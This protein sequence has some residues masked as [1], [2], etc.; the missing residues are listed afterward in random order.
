MMAFLYQ[1]GS[2]SVVKNAR[3]SRWNSFM[4]TP[5]LLADGEYHRLETDAR[6]GPARNQPVWIR[7]WFFFFFAATHG[8]RPRFSQGSSSPEVMLKALATK[9]R[10]SMLSWKSVNAFMR[11]EAREARSFL[12]SR[13]VLKSEPR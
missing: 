9:A 13:I 12:R 7:E 8:D 1:N 11:T 6:R 4:Q 5:N 3:S 10:I 2:L